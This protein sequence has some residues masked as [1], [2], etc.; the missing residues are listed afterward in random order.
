[1]LGELRVDC[2]LDVGAN[3]GQFGDMLRTIG[4]MGTI[5]S[6]EPVDA[7]FRTLAEHAAPMAG[8]EQCGWHWAPKMARQ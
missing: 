4:Y 3:V 6:F 1:M 5:V 7:T 2:V 8:G